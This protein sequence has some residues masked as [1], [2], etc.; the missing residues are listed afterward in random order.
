[1][2]HIEPSRVS[3]LPAPFP[4]KKAKAK[5]LQRLVGDVNRKDLWIVGDFEISGVAVSGRDD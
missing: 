2:N 5:R 1:M 4:H 3:I